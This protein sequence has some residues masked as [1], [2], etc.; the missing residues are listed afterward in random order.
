M[1]KFLHSDLFL[2]LLSAVLL[3]L[4]WL[5]GGSFWILGALVPLLVIGARA[6]RRFL[7]WVVLTLFLWMMATCYWV[8]FATLIATVA[9]PIVGLCFMWPAWALFHLTAKHSKSKALGYVLLVC[10]VVTF[11]WFYSLTDVSFPWLTLGNAFATSPWA[12]QWYSVTGVYGGSVWILVANLLIY[13]GLTKRK[14]CY[15]AAAW[16]VIPLAVSVAMY[17]S[18]KEP[19]TAVNVAVLQPN[20]DPYTEKFDGISAEIQLGELLEIAA[21]AS[22]ATQFYVAPETALVKYVDADNPSGS[23]YVEIIQR[24]LKDRHSGATFIIGATTHRNESIF[25]NSA[26]YI[27]SASVSIYHKSKLVIGV[28]V[29]PEWLEGALNSINLGGYVGS[30]GRQ[31]DRAVYLHSGSAICYESIYGEY[32]A[33]WV[34]NG[35]SVMFVITNDGWWGN[36]PGYRQHFA[37]SRLRALETRRAIGRSANTGRSALISPRGEVIE[38]LGWGERGVISGKLPINNSLTFYVRYGDYIARLAL[39]VYALSLLYAF[40][41]RFRRKV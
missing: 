4:P 5:G 33:Q 10:G 25:Y 15:I 19:A 28:E 23:Y 3:S 40:A 20:V 36:T 31:S 2:S 30:L 29:V 17:W 26:L 41:L 12:V 1:A 7:W 8:S 39:Y 35:A 24:F 32:F 14:V 9:I 21:S 13:T 37:Q 6:E 11:E 38:S 18:Y 34:K 22:D 16:V 27:D